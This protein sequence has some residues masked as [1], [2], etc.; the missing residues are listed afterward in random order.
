MIQ[1]TIKNDIFGFK[2]IDVFQRSTLAAATI[3]V[4]GTGISVKGAARSDFDQNTSV[5]NRLTELLIQHK[6]AFPWG[7]SP[8]LCRGSRWFGTKTVTVT[9]IDQ[10]G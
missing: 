3:K 5:A 10:W 2:S 6:R 8:L 4:K 7:L 9:P 1:P